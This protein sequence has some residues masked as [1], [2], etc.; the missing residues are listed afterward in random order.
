M[1]DRELVDIILTY[2][3]G[4]WGYTLK[5]YISNGYAQ[6]NNHDQCTHLD[7]SGEQ[8]KKIPDELLELKHLKHLNLRWN[9][10]TFIPDELNY[11]KDLHI[12]GNPIFEFK[13]KVEILFNRG[14]TE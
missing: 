1:T 9:K 7:L 10:L 4:N 6:F 2:C 12:S 5:Y 13:D 11:I 3:K 14:F 8:L